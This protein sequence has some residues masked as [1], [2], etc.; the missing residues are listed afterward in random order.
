MPTSLSFTKDKPGLE[1]SG[2]VDAKHIEKDTTTGECKLGGDDKISLVMVRHRGV[3]FVPVFAGRYIHTLTV[4]APTYFGGEVELAW[5]YNS[6]QQPTGGIGEI[7]VR[8]GDQSAVPPGELT[9]SK[10]LA[11]NYRYVFYNPGTH[12]LEVDVFDQKGVK[13]FTDMLILDI[14]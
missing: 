9:R 4:G 12:R 11:G 2:S 5:D 8:I 13:L 14:R 6:L 10:A 3:R 1:F 7:R